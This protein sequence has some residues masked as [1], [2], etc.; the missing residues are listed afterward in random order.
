MWINRLISRVYPVAA[1]L[2]LHSHNELASAATEYDMADA[3][4]PFRRFRD[5]WRRHRGKASTPPRSVL[6]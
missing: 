2:T 1:D 4:Q 6:R 5:R 3:P